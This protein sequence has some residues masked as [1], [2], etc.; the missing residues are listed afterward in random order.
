MALY[1]ITG[2]RVNPN[3]GRI[4]HARLAQIDGATNNWIGDLEIVEASEV[5]S[6]LVAGDTVMSIH[7]LPDGNRVPGA[8]AQ[9]MVFEHGIEGFDTLEP[10]NHAGRTIRDLPPI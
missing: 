10:E 9:Y 2:I 7:S 8:Q 3:N 1:G 4:T 5:A 6:V